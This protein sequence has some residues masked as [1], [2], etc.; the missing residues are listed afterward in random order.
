MAFPEDELA[1]SVVG[2]SFPTISASLSD[3]SV[4]DAS[5]SS[6]SSSLLVAEEKLS[7]LACAVGKA[8]ANFFLPYKV[9]KL[10]QS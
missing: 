7:R 8:W 1:E 5:E 6:K 10:S 3:D 4:D 2:T 9:F